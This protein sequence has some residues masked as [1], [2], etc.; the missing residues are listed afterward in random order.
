M[1]RSCC[2]LA[3]LEGKVRRA[4]DFRENCKLDEAALK[5]L[6]RAAVRANIAVKK[7]R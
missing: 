7:K 4:I 5:D 6:I 1:A 3:S 2:R